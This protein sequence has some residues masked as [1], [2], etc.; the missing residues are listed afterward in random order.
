[1]EGDYVATLRVSDSAS[2]SVP[3]SVTVT[4]AGGSIPLPQ[5]QIDG[6]SQSA[7]R[8]ARDLGNGETAAV[9][10]TVTLD[11]IRSSTIFPEELLFDWEIVAQPAGSQAVLSTTDKNL[12]RLV[13]DLSGTY[14][15]RLRVEDGYNENFG[16]FSFAAS[17]LESP[18]T[19]SP[20]PSPPPSNSGSAGASGGCSLN[21]GRSTANF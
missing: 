19:P 10:S 3:D 15:V 7:G 6:K 11:G 1:M 4:V 14:T 13:P 21:G 17:T 2:Q 18:A 16:E 20:A 9:G 8:P 5:V 12:T